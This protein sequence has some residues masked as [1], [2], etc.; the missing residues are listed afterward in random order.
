M[1]E[2]HDQRVCNVP[3]NI[4]GRGGTGS[5]NRSVNDVD[6]ENES[7][8]D[9][10][11][12][13]L[14]GTPEQKRRLTRSL[15]R[16]SLQMS[17]SEDDFEKEMEME[18]DATMKNHENQFRVNVEKK[19]SAAARS[20]AQQRQSAAPSSG[21]PGGPTQ[22]QC[23]DEVYFDSDEE[24]E[25][26]KENSAEGAKAGGGDED[27][28]QAKKQHRI[29]TNDDLLYDPNIDDDNQT[30]MNKQRAQ[31]YP[32]RAPKRSHDLA[33]SESPSGTGASAQSIRAPKPDQAEGAKS[34]ESIPKTDAI[35][36]CPACMTTLC[37]DC[38]RH[39]L[40]TN[41]YRAMFVMNCCI[42]RSE[43][44]RYPESKNKKKWRKKRRHEGG[45]V[46]EEDGGASTG[47]ELFHPVKC[48][49]CNT[50]VAVLDKQE[51]YHFFNV[52]SSA[53]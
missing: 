6:E 23:Y 45:E 18:L 50:E 49:I 29:P 34:Q 4:F 33:S 3:F 32:K 47:D 17:S 46:D 7:S 35:L 53:A 15:S 42:V 22:Q 19:L 14:N 27:K 1:D 26:K 44:L 52:L 40:Y 39:E 12:I 10:L 36:N 5:G 21:H 38:Q 25:E 43:Q 13:I 11:D 31:Y 30:W 20:I 8:E 37:I 51:I 24:E 41:Q 48:A 2:D 16:G 9:E 28:E